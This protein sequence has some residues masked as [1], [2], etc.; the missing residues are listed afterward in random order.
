MF[1]QNGLTLGQAGF[2]ACRV[3]KSQNAG[4]EPGT[5]VQAM[6]AS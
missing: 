6:R 1:A 5:P 3:E 4:P 2:V